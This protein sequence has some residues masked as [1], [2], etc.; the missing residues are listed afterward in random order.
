M[1]EVLLQLQ[2]T[3]RQRGVAHPKM[4]ELVR[5]VSRWMDGYRRSRREKVVIVSTLPSRIS[6]TVVLACPGLE[7]SRV[8]RYKHLGTS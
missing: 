2:L 4:H 6:V 3:C 7:G 8:S 1:K 5:V